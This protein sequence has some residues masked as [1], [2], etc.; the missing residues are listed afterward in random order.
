[1]GHTIS[2]GGLSLL[3]WLW[4]SINRDCN[5]GSEM[6]YICIT[7]SIS[8]HLTSPINLGVVWRRL[9]RFGWIIQ[10]CYPNSLRM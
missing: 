3:T 5:L 1:M 7:I 8:P 9:S 4:G 10:N 6:G 2:L